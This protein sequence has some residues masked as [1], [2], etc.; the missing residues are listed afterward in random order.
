MLKKLQLWIY[1]RFFMSLVVLINACHRRRM[2]HNNG[3]AARG[4]VRVVDNPEWPECDFF[5]PGQEFVCRIRH[6]T[7]PYVDDAMIAV[8]SLSIKFADT[9][10][11]SPCDLQMNTGITSFFWTA[12]T[13]MAFAFN[14]AESNGTEYVK[15]YRKYSM[16]GPRNSYRRNPSSFT[17]LYYNGQTPFEFH[18]KDGVKRYIK[19]R[20]IPEDRG[21]ESGLV[22]PALLQTPEQCADQRVLPGET[23]GRAYLRNEYRERVARQGARYHLQMQL[24]EAKAD[25][26]PELFSVMTRWDEATHP[27]MDWMTLTV[28]EVL[29]YEA[30]VVTSFEVS[31]LPQSISLIPATSIDDYNSL[32]YFRKQSIWA[33]RT[34]FFFNR[35]FGLP[36]QYPDEGPRNER[37][38]WT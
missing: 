26:D 13:F 5:H 30:S 20:A 8:R 21:E 18:A 4:K 28:D 14:R 6:A 29:D 17:Q 31:N 23:C 3:I 15:Y 16:T 37:A 32:N 7:V 25:D 33:I 2:S 36:K 34:R 1:A 38:P 12:R 11:K 19:F 22:D 27:W 35:I 10:F 9:N 24:H